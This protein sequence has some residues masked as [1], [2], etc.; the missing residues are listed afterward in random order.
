MKTIYLGLG[1]NIG[2]RASNLRAATGELAAGGVRILRASPIYETEPVDYTQQRWFLNQVVEAE[3]E[4]FPMQLL[5][6]IGK[7]ESGLGRVRTV[8]KGPRTID[9]DILFYGERVIS[10][11]DELHVP[12]LLVH[13]RAFVLRPLA[14]VA[15]DFRHPILYRTVREML[16]EVEDDHTVVEAADVPAEWLRE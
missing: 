16:A 10:V 12:H 14:E 1:S 7:I 6:R 11:P 3:T 9:I 8:A 5:S 2:D 13:E 15:P 4:L